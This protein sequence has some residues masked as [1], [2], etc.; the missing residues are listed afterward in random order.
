MSSCVSTFSIFHLRRASY[1][2]TADQ[3]IS[4]CGDFL[5]HRLKANRDEKQL[6]AISRR[7]SS[8]TQEGRRFCHEWQFSTPRPRRINGRLALLKFE[9]DEPNEKST[10]KFTQHTPLK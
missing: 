3:K 2:D 8:K 9:S 6:W 7:K 5:S 1:E 4:H 10:S